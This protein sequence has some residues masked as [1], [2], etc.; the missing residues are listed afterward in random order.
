MICPCGGLKKFSEC[1]QLFHRK[2][3]LAEH[4]VDLMKARYSAF[5]VQDMDF[6]RFTH[7]PQTMQ[8]FDFELNEKWAKS[9]R[10]NSLQIL[11]SSEEKN[12]AQVEFLVT[13]TEL[14]SGEEKKH[15]ELSK[16]RKQAGVWFFKEGKEI[17]A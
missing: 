1:C 11:Q 9:V 16:F 2:D 6:I 5:C 7:D 15:H 8:N 4:A 12:K 3:K 10:F 13:Y 17:Q 14:A